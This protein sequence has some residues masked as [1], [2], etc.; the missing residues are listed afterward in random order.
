[1]TTDIDRAN[2][3]TETKNQFFIESFKGL[4]VIN[5]GAAVAL[6]TWL[7]AVWDKPW[8]TPMLRSQVGA[9]AAFAVGVSF[10]AFAPVIRYL[11][12]HHRMAATPTKNPLWWIN[13]VVVILSVLA[14]AVGCG[15]IVRGAFAAL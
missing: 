1:M 8:A 6:A 12:F 14:F 13:V 5:G 11:A 2:V 9:L 7:Q 3:L 10:G 15:M 4:V